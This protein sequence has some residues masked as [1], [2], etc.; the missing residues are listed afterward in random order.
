MTRS[1]LAS[2]LLLAASMAL[3]AFA[4]SAQ[5]RADQYKIGDRLEAPKG[6]SAP[7]KAKSSFRELKWDDLISPE[8]NPEAFIKSLNLDMMLDT[9]SRAIAAMEQL[10]QEWNNAPANPALD[11]AQVRLPGF[12]VPL[13]R[14]GTALKE[15]LLVPYFGAC[16]HVPPPPANQIVHVIAAKPV[17]DTATM[18]AVWVSGKLTL[19]RVQTHLGRSAY[20]LQA[21]K[22]E[23][24]T[25]KP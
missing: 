4:Q 21:A 10:K 18:D 11:N 5:S 19:E 17:P 23:P 20:R 22:I 15:F 8:W 7:S 12:V 6:A 9:D 25:K 2:T 16:I 13:E 1:L 14:E 3:P 24:Y